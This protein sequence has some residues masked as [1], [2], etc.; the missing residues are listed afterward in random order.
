MT[1]TACWVWLGWVGGV[2][3]GAWATSLHPLGKLQRAIEMPEGERDNP[4]RKLRLN[5]DGWMETLEEA[6]AVRESLCLLSS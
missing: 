1:T 3:G 2:L 5:S 6:E 4:N